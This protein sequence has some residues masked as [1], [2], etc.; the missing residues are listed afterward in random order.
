MEAEAENEDE[1]IT[2]EEQQEFH[3]ED[4][5]E[6]QRN[7]NDEVGQSTDAYSVR[8]SGRRGHTLE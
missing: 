7:A 2:P 6:E 3:D 8:L 1:E 4:G 5:N